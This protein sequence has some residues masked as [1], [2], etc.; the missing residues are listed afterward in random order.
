[1]NLEIIHL[2]LNACNES[3]KNLDKIY[4]DVPIYYENWDLD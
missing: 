1:M 3:I 2:Q 4:C